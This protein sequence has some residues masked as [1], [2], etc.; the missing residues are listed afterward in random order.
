MENRKEVQISNGAE[1]FEWQ[2]RAVHKYNA[3]LTVAGD[4]VKVRFYES[5]I[6]C[7][8]PKNQSSLKA[9]AQKA[10]AEYN[11]AERFAKTGKIARRRLFNMV[12]ASIG[13]KDYQGKKQRFKFITFT[14]R[15]DVKDLTVANKIFKDFIA[16]LNY[17][18]VGAD[19]E[20]FIQYVAVPELQMENKR[21]VWHYHVLFFNLPFI[22]VASEMVERLIEKGSLPADY[23]KR[24]TLFCL[25]GQGT[26]DAV[27]VKLSDAYDI[28]GYISK[29]IGKGLEGDF[30]YAESHGLLNR[31]RFLHSAGVK[32]PAVFIAFMNKAQRQAVFSEFAKHAKH[33]KRNNKIGKYFETF[34]F[35]CEYIG[36]MF[37]IDCRSPQKYI[38]KI[39]AVFEKYSY[40]FE[41]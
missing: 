6:M 16:R 33:F 34:E 28:C 15:N 22:P 27:A 24:D 40:G 14:F 3:K 32:N 12:G 21:E 7:N 9:E 36:K 1:V 23:D 2:G 38:Q 37:G 8:Y 25:W 30:K 10:K 29:Y 39:T 26:V 13:I 17:F 4:A 19:G 5:G 20:S 35:D 41:A 31:K 11:K 18:F